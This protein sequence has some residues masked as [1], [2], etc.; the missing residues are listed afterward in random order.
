MRLFQ[1]FILLLLTSNLG[2]AQNI[3]TDSP[4][5]LSNIQDARVQLPN[6]YRTLNL[7]FEAMKSILENAPMEFTAA[8]KS[9]PLVIALPMPDGR[10]ENFEVVE[11]PIMEQ[12]LSDKFPEIKTYIVQGVDNPTAS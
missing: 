6:N 7:D 3:W 12:G 9:Q 1:L 5:V 4:D 8:A 2:L 11:S 10:M